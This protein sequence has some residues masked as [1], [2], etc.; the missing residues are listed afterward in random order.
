M[1]R[2]ERRI[3]T[4]TAESWA[5]CLRL[6]W[7]AARL[8]S[9][10]NKKEEGDKQSLAVKN[11]NQKGPLRQSGASQACPLEF[12]LQSHTLASSFSVPLCLSLG[13]LSAQGPHIITHSVYDVSPV[14]PGWAQF[15][16]ERNFSTK[17]SWIDTKNGN[18]GYLLSELR[19]VFKFL[20][21][22]IFPKFLFFFFF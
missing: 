20:F 14:S 6:R 8:D 10:T 9:R 16:E 7:G 21:Q 19:L 18:S 22:G 4:N 13:P 11:K 15:C 2:G 12:C 17:T 5:P 3:S 1:G